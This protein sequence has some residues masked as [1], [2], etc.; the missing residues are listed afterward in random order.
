MKREKFNDVLGECFGVTVKPLIVAGA[1]ISYPLA[2]IIATALFAAEDSYKRNRTQ[3][4]IQIALDDLYAKVERIEFS[5]SEN[6]TEIIK[7]KLFPLFW[8][9]VIEEQEVDKIQL[10]VNGVF[11]AVSNEEINMEKMY[12]YFDILKSLRLKEIHYFLEVYINEN[13]KIVENG[14]S[15]KYPDDL[16]L[17]YHKYVINKL[18]RLGLINLSVIDGNGTI[19]EHYN[20]TY[21]G[22]EINNYFNSL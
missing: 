22:H 13:Y 4:N 16:D 8:D 15:I 5:L 20:I 7:E 9:S 1:T 17:G 12:V 11:S 19:D 21:L 18:E 2:G 3:K 10:F 14:F 6:S